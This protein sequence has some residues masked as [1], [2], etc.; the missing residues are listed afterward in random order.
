MRFRVVT[1]SD[2]TTLGLVD[3]GTWLRPAVVSASPE[4]KFAGASGAR[5]ELT[6]PL[7]RAEAGGTVE[8]VVEILLTGIEGG[9]PLVFEIGRGHLGSTTVELA[10]GFGAGAAVIAS[11]VWDG[12]VPG[13]LNALQFPV[14]AASLVEPAP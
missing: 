7:A 4:A 12:I 1:S 3:G 11:Q 14:P 13:E 5:F 8:M 9:E 6:Q 10:K 2:W